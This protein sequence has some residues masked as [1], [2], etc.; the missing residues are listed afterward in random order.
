MFIDE[1]PYVEVPLH[2][3]IKLTPVA[4][5]C[6]VEEIRM[7]VAAVNTHRARPTVEDEGKA[8]H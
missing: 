1:L 2:T 4:Y 5:G 6:R 8:S 3:I 7:P